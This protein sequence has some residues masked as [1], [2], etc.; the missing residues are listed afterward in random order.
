MRK[1]QECITNFNSWSQR[2]RFLKTEGL[3]MLKEGCGA[4]FCKYCDKCS[5]P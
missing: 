4:R 2:I 3:E 5:N 1:L